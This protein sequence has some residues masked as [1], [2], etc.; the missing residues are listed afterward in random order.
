[1]IAGKLLFLKEKQGGRTVGVFVDRKC[2]LSASVP[3][4]PHPTPFS[5]EPGSARGC[6]VAWKVHWRPGDWIDP[7]FLARKWEIVGPGRPDLGPSLLMMMVMMMWSPEPHILS[8]CYSFIIYLEQRRSGYVGWQVRSP[9]K[10]GW[11][12]LIGAVKRMTLKDCE[13]TYFHISC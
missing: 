4:Q 2:C 8:P 11:R 13:F 1:M 3:P 7:V 5:H 6:K 12:H 10:T 9:D